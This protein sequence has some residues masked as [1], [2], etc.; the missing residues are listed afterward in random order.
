MLSKLSPCT[1]RGVESSIVPINSPAREGEGDGNPV[2]QCSE[3]LR[4]RPD[5]CDLVEE[6]ALERSMR[7]AARACRQ[8]A[9]HV[10]CLALRQRPV[11]ILPQPAHRGGARD[12]GAHPAI[13]HR[14]S[15]WCPPP[16]T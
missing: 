2:T 3:L 4:F 14:E 1:R 16:G 13:L 10:A 7:P 12:H 9:A 8:V 15:A 5:R 6:T 11:Q